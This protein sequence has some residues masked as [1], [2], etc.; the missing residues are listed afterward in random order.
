[1]SVKPTS[2][3]EPT[4]FDTAQ[5]TR[6]ADTPNAANTAAKK[7][8]Q[9]TSQKTPQNAS[10]DTAQNMAQ[11]LDARDTALRLLGNVLQRK[12]TLDQALDRDQSFANLPARDKAF[13]RMLTATTLR[14]M[15][16]VDDLIARAET[17]TT[18]KPPILQDILRIG[19]V[20]ILFMDVPDHA[21][22][23]TAVRLTEKHRLGRQKAFVN[24]LLRTMTR[25]GHDWMLTQ[26]EARLNTPDWLL[27]TWINDYGLRFAAEIARANL[28]EAP[29]DITIK[30][31]AERLYWEGALKASPIGAASLRRMEGGAVTDMTGFDDGGWWVQDAAAALPATLL[32]DNLRGKHVL[33]LCA[34]PGGKTMQLAAMGAHVTA[35]DRSAKRLKRLEDNLLRTKLSENVT[36][37]VADGAQWRPPKDN[38]PDYILLD[39]PCSATGTIRRHPD[40]PHLKSPDDIARLN[41]IQNRILDNAFDMLARGGT[42]IYCTCSLQKSEGEAQITRLLSN[43]PDAYKKAISAMEIGG[44]TEAITDD[45][46]VRLLPFHQ[47]A[48]GGMDGFFVARIKKND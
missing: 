17:R 9:D 15:G 39:A 23:D 48:R 47:V 42:L 34:A 41:S 43:R 14:R 21:A 33:D 7:S 5:S 1:M 40:M 31:T 20:Q 27:K 38:A 4:L 22:V 46:D 35:L 13:C 18:T 37:T 6:G 12:Q 36:I 29:L 10:K 45:G 24:G 11:G 3:T 32:T 25:N 44:I 8:A 2:E 28:V 26:D 19:V 16:Q 30:D